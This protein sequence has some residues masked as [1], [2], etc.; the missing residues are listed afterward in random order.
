V[1]DWD[2]LLLPP[3]S[4]TAAVRQEIRAA[5]PT[6]GV[7]HVTTGDQARLLTI[8]VDRLFASM[9]SIFGAIALLLASVGVY[10]VLSY[11]VAHRTQEIGVRMALGATQRN[12]FGLIIGQGARLAGV[13]LL[14]GLGGAFGVTRIIRS[15]LYNVGPS[16]LLSFVVP[17][18][19]LVLVALA[20][21]FVPAQRAT[22][23][24][25]LI[26]LRFE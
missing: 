7:F 1:T 15:L 4:L 25:P 8:W 20:A 14:L 9:F 17:A 19:F 12:V 2:W 6:L 16:D 24:A 22:S 26:A 23:V 13:G 3:A 10:G 5:D 21:S 11:A 18:V